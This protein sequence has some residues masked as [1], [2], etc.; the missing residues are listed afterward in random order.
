MASKK[1]RKAAKRRARN[2]QPYESVGT[3]ISPDSGIIQAAQILD[4]AGFAAQRSG[5]VKEMIS[6]STGWLQ[7]SAV[8]AGVQQAAEAQAESEA[9]TTQTEL[10]FRG[11]VGYDSEEDDLVEDTQDRVI[12][13][14]GFRGTNV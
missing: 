14:M 11:Q 1:K 4:I 3:N 7:M 12:T 13:T 2:A 10:G 6:V 5:D 9:L 8:L